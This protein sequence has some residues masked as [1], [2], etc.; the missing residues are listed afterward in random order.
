[1]SQA[2]DGDSFLTHDLNSRINAQLLFMACALAGAFFAATVIL[3]V[4]L[5]Y[6]YTNNTFKRSAR[7]SD[8]KKPKLNNHQTHTTSSSYYQS[9]ESTQNVRTSTQDL[10]Q[11]I[12]MLQVMVQQKIVKDASL[13]PQLQYQ[14]PLIASHFGHSIND[15]YQDA[16]NQRMLR[17]HSDDMVFN[18]QLGNNGGAHVSAQVHNRQWMEFL[19]YQRRKALANAQSSPYTMHNASMIN[20]S[21]LNED[22]QVEWA[23]DVSQRGSSELCI[24]Q[25]PI[26]APVKHNN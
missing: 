25:Q 24:E 17:T 10:L 12:Q 14:S 1:M 20:K 16:S 19:E 22:L 11:Q 6:C 3:L 7:V 21:D 18:K 26:F 23:S 4:V 15:S 5:Y 13:Q 2:M 9:S 8:D